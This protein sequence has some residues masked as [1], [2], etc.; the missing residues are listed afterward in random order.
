MKGDIN[1]HHDC[2]GNVMSPSRKDAAESQKLSAKT[3]WMACDIS[4]MN[5][6]LLVRL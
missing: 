1:M 3:K 5:K 2:I 4:K 6:P